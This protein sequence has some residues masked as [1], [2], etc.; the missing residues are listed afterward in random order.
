MRKREKG[1]HA[2]FFDTCAESGCAPSQRGGGREGGGGGV[3]GARGEE[4]ESER[5]IEI[6]RDC[7]SERERKREKRRKASEMETDR[8]PC[9]HL[10]TTAES[11][12]WP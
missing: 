6:N 8:E 11:A 5:E 12:D 3:R 1:D 9:V 2:W 10:S 7:D 4:R